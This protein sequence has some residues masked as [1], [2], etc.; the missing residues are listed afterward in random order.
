[1]AKFVPDLTQAYNTNRGDIYDP[2]YE[3]EL[4]PFSND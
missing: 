3:L 2:L 1:M 4:P